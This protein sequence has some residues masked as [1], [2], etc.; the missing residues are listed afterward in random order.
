MFS[1][2]SGGDKIQISGHLGMNEN[3]EV[4]AANVDNSFWRPSWEGQERKIRE[5]R[6]D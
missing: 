1:S 6:F 5:K 4:E 2:S 3:E